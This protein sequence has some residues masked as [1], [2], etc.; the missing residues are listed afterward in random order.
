MAQPGEVSQVI[1]E[2]YQYLFVAAL[3]KSIRGFE[4][5]F[6]VRTASEKTSFTGRSGKLFSFDF[7][8]LYDSREVFGECKGYSK[9]TSLLPEFRSFLAKAYVTSNDYPRQHNDLF[10][11]ITN[12]PFAC[13]EGSGI[14]TV[15]FVKTTLT[16]KSHAQVQEILGGGHVDD[17]AISRLVERLGV[18]ILT[19]SFLRNVTLSYKV[20]KG[21]TYWGILRKLHGGRIPPGNFRKRAETMAHQ[22][23]LRSPDHIVA[24]QRL[25]LQ[26]YGLTPSDPRASGASY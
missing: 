8:G 19:D 3:E 20:K 7:S 15:Q 26:W 6:D 16:D 17:E 4:S 13:N 14:R 2:T 18:F 11:F 25:D 12:V 10:W 24:G 22:N 5:K 1:G 23:R 9:G 21:E